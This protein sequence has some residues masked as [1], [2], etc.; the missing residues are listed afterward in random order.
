MAE[1]LRLRLAIG[2]LAAALL[3]GMAGYVLI[4]KWPLF[5]A[6]YMSIVTLSTVGFGEIHPLSRA[7]R[8]FTIFFILLGRGAETYLAIVFAQVIVVDPLRDVFG[9]RRMEQEL[10]RIADHYIVCGWGRMGKEIVRQIQRKGSGC[11]VVEL[12]E[13]NCRLLAEQQILH[14]HGDA[15]DDAVLLDAGVERARGLIC[16]ASRDADNIFITLSAR[17]LNR[18]LLIVAR[19]ISGQDVHKLEIAGA[20]RVI[21]PYVIGARR[22]AAALFHPGVVDFLDLE[23]RHEE[24]EWEL[25]DVTIGASSPLAGKTIGEIREVAG[26]TVL[27]V[28]Q[29]AARSFTRSPG[30]ELRPSPGDTLICLGTPEQLA[31]LKSLTEPG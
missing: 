14:V 26:C 10:G 31:K 1:Y 19:S 20:D 2:L 11:V 7:G 23:V 6:F 3:F 22:M 25:D 15:S 8:V 9:R 4:E 27:A 24:L 18:K 5:D 28:R 29:G 12:S 13:E 21:S 17:A 16:V 30:V